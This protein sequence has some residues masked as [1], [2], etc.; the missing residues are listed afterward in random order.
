MYMTETA[1]TERLVMSWDAPLWVDFA[2]GLVSGISE[3]LTLFWLKFCLGAT[4]GVLAG[5]AGW[6]AGVLDGLL[7][8]VLAGDLDGLTTGLQL[9]TA[10]VPPT[11]T[12]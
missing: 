9:F 10:A 5:C 7:D 1:A 8:G 2:L 4:A 6:V 11:V 12:A 3:I